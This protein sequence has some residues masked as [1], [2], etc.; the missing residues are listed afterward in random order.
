MPCSVF[1]NCTEI[2]T[3]S[4]VIS[5]SI[6]LATFFLS[7]LSWQHWPRN[8][9][10]YM[11]NSRISI[12]QTAGLL[13]SHKMLFHRPFPVAMLIQSLTPLWMSGCPLCQFVYVKFAPVLDTN[14]PADAR[15]KPSMQI[16][17]TDLSAKKNH[18]YLDV[19]VFGRA[20]GVR[21]SLMCSGKAKQLTM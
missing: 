1:P 10:V 16:Q 9:S 3:Q 11:I 20:G 19:C 17:S 7:N 12:S 2:L 15:L 5:T 4:N 18:V 8:W 14:A 21:T 6:I 13:L